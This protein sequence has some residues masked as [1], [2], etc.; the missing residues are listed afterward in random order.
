MVSTLQ[1]C[2]LHDHVHDVLATSCAKF[3]FPAYLK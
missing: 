3:Y 1:K 2:V